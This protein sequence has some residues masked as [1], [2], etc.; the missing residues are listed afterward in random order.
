MMAALEH[1]QFGYAR[2]VLINYLRYYVLPSGGVFYRGLEMAQSARILTNVAQYYEY[3]QDAKP[4]IKYL[5]K[6]QAVF[7]LLMKRRAAALE[8]PSTDPAY[9]CLTAMTRR[10]CMAQR[11]ILSTRQRWHSCQSPQRPGV[12]SET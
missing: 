9:G 6:I 4:L 12:G 10:I 7:G 1:G 3:T 11:L 5:P 2:E 8:L